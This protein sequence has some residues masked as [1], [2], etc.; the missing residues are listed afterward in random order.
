MQI[1]TFLLCKPCVLEQYVNNSGCNCK[2]YNIG[3]MYD[4]NNHVSW[5]KSLPII[6]VHFYPGINIKMGEKSVTDGNNY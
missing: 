2:T 3:L 4:I 5:K 6:A 1:R